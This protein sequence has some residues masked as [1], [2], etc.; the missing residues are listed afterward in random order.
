M[1]KPLMELVLPRLAQRLH[2]HLRRYQ[3]GKLS[4]T[5][6]SRKFEILM[7]QQFSWLA[8]QGVPE[9]QAAVAVHAAVIVL[10]RPG[11]L[12]EADEQEVPLEVIEYNA[13]LG[14]AQDIAQTYGVSERRCARRISSLV[15]E[16]AD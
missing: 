14:A 4:D 5:Q 12:A 13:V 10:S 2:R 15:A 6:F 16:Y 3:A 1:N 8:N 7:Q 9:A 11:L